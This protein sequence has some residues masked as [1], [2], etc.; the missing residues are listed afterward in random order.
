MRVNTA[1]S[2]RLAEVKS[3]LKTATDAELVRLAAAMRMNDNDQVTTIK[4][5]IENLKVQTSGK[6]GVALSADQSAEIDSLVAQS[7]AHTE[8]R[9]KAVE[10]IITERTK[11]KANQDSDNDGISN[12]DE[13]AIYKTNPY[14]AD[15]DNDGFTDGAEILSGYDPLDAKTEVLVAYESPKET[16]IVRDDILAVTSISTAQPNEI[17][18]T[19]ATLSASTTPVA[20]ISG[21]APVNSFVTLYIFSTPTVVTIKTDA[22]GSWNYRFDKELEDGEHQVYIGVTDNAGKIIAKSNPFNFIKKA[23]AFTGTDAASG[24]AAVPVIVT[25]GEMLSD[26]SVYGVLAVSVIAIALLLLLLGLHLETAAR[27]KPGVISSE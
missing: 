17:A 12:Y 11:E 3:V 7:V 23:E 19:T 1:S 24:P 10:K 22:D 20:L 6:L 15:T 18:T 16:G 2:S 25:D 26:Y 27:N 5:R 21:K 8:E 14:R 9:V 13:V 4:A